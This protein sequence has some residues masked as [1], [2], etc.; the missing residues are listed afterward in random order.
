[1]N[2]PFI[3]PTAEIDSTARIGQNSKI[4]SYSQVCRGSQLGENVVVGRNVYIGV[5][6]QIGSFSKI[7]NNALIYEP[8][9]VEEGVFIGPG[10]I[11]TNDTYPRAI[12][13]DGIQRGSTDWNIVGVKVKRG[14]SVGAGA[15]CI[16]PLEI[17]EWALIAAGS[18]VTRNVPNFALVAGIPARK[19]GWVGKLG[20]P[21]D[22]LGDGRF[23][24]PKSGDNYLQLD[25]DTLVEVNP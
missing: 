25:E 8:A 16:A 18:T 14:A 7:Q 3:H 10:A 23:A 17:G 22:S 13:P 19:I 24:C 9:I 12:N 4:W 21:L 11:L 20:L 15:V 1:M 6:V 5:G 2:D